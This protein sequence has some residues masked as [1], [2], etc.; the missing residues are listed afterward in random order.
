MDL[1]RESERNSAGPIMGGGHAEEAA[2]RLVVL[3]G[4]PVLPVQE[5]A[6][7]IDGLTDADQRLI[8]VI[9]QKGRG[10]DLVR[11]GRLENGFQLGGELAG[12]LADLSG[13]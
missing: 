9:E 7:L 3:A 6:D 12:D 8:A 10:L 4:G 2:G 11:R 13:R 5:Q 1:G